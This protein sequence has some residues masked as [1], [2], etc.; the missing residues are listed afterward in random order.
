MNVRV[1]GSIARYPRMLDR[2]LARVALVDVH[3]DQVSNE[4]LG[5]VRN[6]IPV[7]TLKFVVAC[8]R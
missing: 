1:L 4:V 7:G 3:T 8:L 6:L 2:L 5:G